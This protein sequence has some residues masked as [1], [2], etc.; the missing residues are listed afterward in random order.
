[1]A[2]LLFGSLIGLLVMILLA[3]LGG[4][5]VQRADLSRALL[6]PLW[7]IPVLTLAAVSIVVALEAL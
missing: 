4:R 3:L 5:I 6:L 7:S 1:M 2:T